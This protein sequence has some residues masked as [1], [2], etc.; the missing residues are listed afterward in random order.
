MMLS[1]L[2]IGLAALVIYVLPWLLKG[3]VRLRR[4]L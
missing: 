4:I 3:F 2:V 1:A